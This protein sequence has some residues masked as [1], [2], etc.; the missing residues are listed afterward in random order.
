MWSVLEKQMLD[1]A[2]P[3]PYCNMCLSSRGFIEQSFGPAHP[4]TKEYFVSRNDMQ[5]EAASKFVFLLSPLSS[6]FPSLQSPFVCPIEERDREGFMERGRI[7]K[8]LF[9]FDRN[10]T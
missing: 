3:I 2:K 10:Q 8:I 1:Q 5:K 9:Q 4:F 6:F 7:E